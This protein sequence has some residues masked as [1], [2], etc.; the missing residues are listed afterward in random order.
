MAT[1]LADNDE[2]LVLADGTKIDP[3][4]GRVIRDPSP[5]YVAVPSPSEAQQLVTRVRRTVADLPLP[6]NQ[7]SAVGM[8]AFYALFGLSEHD[9]SLALNGK[10]SVEQI[11][12][13]KTLDAYSEFM[14]NA[15]TNILETETNVVRDMFQRH[16]V[17]AA[18]KVITLAETAESEV[19]SFKA[20]QDVLDRA[21][22][23][24]A[25]IVEHRHTME[26]ALHVVITKR[27]E[28]KEI[29]TI[30][31]VVLDG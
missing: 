18:Q 25:D 6:P 8:V 17:N 19:L 29:P 7:M 13:I 9:T 31:G 28:T 21:G 20:A 4:T 2:P 15:K 10:L 12:E 30:D 11:Q 3:T 26:D 16:A 24:P 14:D 27:D 22:H 5:A 23:R 1:Q